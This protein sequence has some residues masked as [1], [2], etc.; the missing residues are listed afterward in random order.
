MIK[1][2]QW[3]GQQ[4]PEDSAPNRSTCFDCKQKRVRIAGA[5]HQAYR[6]TPEWLEK[7]KLR[8]EQWARV[9]Q[10]REEK[11]KRREAGRLSTDLRMADILEHRTADDMTLEQLATKWGVTRER[12]RQ[13][14]MVGRRLTGNS[15]KPEF[16]RECGYCH[17]NFFTTS[18]NKKYCNK[19]CARLATIEK[20]HTPEAIAKRKAAYRK[21]RP[22]VRFLVKC[23]NPSC[24]NMVSVTKDD[25]KKYCGSF[26]NRIGC[27][28]LNQ[29]HSN[30]KMDYRFKEMLGPVMCQHC[31][32]EIIGKNYRAKWCKDCDYYAYQEREKRR[33]ENERQLIREALEELYYEHLDNDGHSFL[34]R[35][36]DGI[37]QPAEGLRAVDLQKT[38]S[39]NATGRRDDSLR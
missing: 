21:P 29:A 38:E 8:D 4:L 30:R 18:R 39:G 19:V 12:I 6:H 32:K 13:I 35:Q 28:W 7:K 22:K 33:D 2:C 1:F 27:S 31:G 34:P 14:E 17:R 10:E 36:N 25:N 26:R 37:L 20:L 9:Q 24:P 5:I 11:R 15:T 3:C 23:A 16:D